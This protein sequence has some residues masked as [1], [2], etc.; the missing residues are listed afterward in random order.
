MSAAKQLLASTALASVLPPGRLVS[1]TTGCRMEAAI[2]TL[3]DSGILSVPVLKAGVSMQ[4]FI[5]LTCGPPLAGIACAARRTQVAVISS[6]NGAQATGVPPAAAV[7][8]AAARLLPLAA[9]NIIA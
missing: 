6:D 4:R 3:H 7:A 5:T 2:K 1:V 9:D 8:A